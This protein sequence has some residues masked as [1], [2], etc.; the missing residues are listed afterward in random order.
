[1]SALA[2]DFDQHGNLVAF[3]GSVRP[4][5]APREKRAPLPAPLVQPTALSPQA[6]RLDG[7]AL[8]KLDRMRLYDAR[9]TP[10]GRELEQ[11]VMVQLYLAGWR[12][13]GLVF[14]PDNWD[15]QRKR[16]GPQ[17]QVFCWVR[18]NP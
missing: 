16:Y 5:P 10:I 6:L 15:P 13:Y 17:P 4:A 7:G 8:W 12:L 14:G 18:R 11:A 2:F 1:M 9:S 3:P